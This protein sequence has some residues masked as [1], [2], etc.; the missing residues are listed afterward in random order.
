MYH[1]VSFLSNSRQPEHYQISNMMICQC[2]CISQYDQTLKNTE[3]KLKI[4]DVI[5]QRVSQ[6]NFLGIILQ[7]N[8]NWKSD[9]QKIG[10]NKK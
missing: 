6:F 2:K 8:L 9:L 7:E 3:L 10:I 4:D 5:I 1:K